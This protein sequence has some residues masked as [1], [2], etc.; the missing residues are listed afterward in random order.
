MKL[1]MLKAQEIRERLTAH[2]IAFYKSGQLFIERVHA[3][4]MVCKAGLNT[5]HVSAAL[6][7]VHAFYYESS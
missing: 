4:A 3:L 2:G 7:I 6:I 1:I 5:L